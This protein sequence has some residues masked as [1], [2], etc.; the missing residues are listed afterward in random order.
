MS[1]RDWPPK[2]HTKKSNKYIIQTYNAIFRTLLIDKLLENITELV[3]AICAT[4]L[5]VT[6]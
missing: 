4:A 1:E 6:E 5:E 2:I 3:N